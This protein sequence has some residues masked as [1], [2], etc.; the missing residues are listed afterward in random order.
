MKQEKKKKIIIIQFIFIIILLIALVVLIKTNIWMEDL[1]EGNVPQ[2]AQISEE[3]SENGNDEYSSDSEDAEMQAKEPAVVSSKI[4]SFL[5][6]YIDKAEMR[7]YD[8]SL[9]GQQVRLNDFSV[10][11][12]EDRD[13]RYIL[14]FMS[15]DCEYCQ[16]SMFYIEEYSKQDGAY[17]VEVYSFQDDPVD[18]ETWLKE[19][20]QD[21]TIQPALKFELEKVLNIKYMPCFLFIEDHTIKFAFTNEISS[22]MQFDEMLEI[23]YGGAYDAE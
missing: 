15:I 11:E 18:V 5:N 3:Q 16:R 13:G 9:I 22:T 20:D 17:P 19:N 21:I 6:D 8:I 10:G 7:E 1:D 23:A 4:Q 14:E 2:R 12:K